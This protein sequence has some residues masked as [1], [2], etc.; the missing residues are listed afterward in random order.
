MSLRLRLSLLL[1][2]LNL[3]FLLVLLALLL[4]NQRA[5]IAEEIT[6][7]HRVTVQLL[8]TAAQTSGLTG[9]APLVMETFLRRLGRVRA[10]EIRLYD[11]R[12]ELRYVSPPSH[13]KQSRQAPEPFARLMTPQLEATGFDLPG[14]RLLIV[15]DASR[16]VLD[17]W[18]DLTSLVLLW[19][20]FFVVLQ[21]SLL[22]FLRHLLRPAETLLVGLDQ[23]A[24]GRFATRLAE[25]PVSEWREL[26]SGFNRVAAAL[27]RG[28]AEQ[29]QLVLT[30]EALAANR[31]VTRFIEAGIEAERK[32]LARELHDELGQSVTA[33]RLIATSLARHA[34]AGAEIAA[35]AGKINEVAASLYDGV[36]RIVRELRPAVLERSDLAAAL[37]EI[38]R[39]WRQQ[40]PDIALTLATRGDCSHLGEALTLAAFRVVQEALTNVLKHA[41]ARRVDI[42]LCR[43]TG[44]LGVCVRDDGRG[45]AAP[46]GMRRGLAGM[47][48]RAALL[49]GTLAAGA[50][51]E[52]G[53]CVTLNLPLNEKETPSS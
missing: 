35:G 30:T 4:G 38:A 40:H 32:R 52:G 25:S 50:A 10:N 2:V 26:T 14:A 34:G 6:A 16:A 41:A 12:G 15:P 46:A 47:R 33:I 28:Q 19:L 53:F 44:T 21:V 31:E 24:H 27:E 43:E 45:Q 11:S 3:G 51:A 22:L 36:Q 37:E 7:A 49:G 1:G 39:E 42:E 18:D 23:L 48:E 13:Y 9:P 5:S 29:R 17:A 8:G 20:G